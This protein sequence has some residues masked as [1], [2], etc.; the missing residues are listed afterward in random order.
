MGQTST[1]EDRYI[2]LVQPSPPH[3]NYQLWG[4]PGT[5]EH[6]IK[7]LLAYRPGTDFGWAIAKFEMSGEVRAK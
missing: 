6:C 5:I 2:A 7:A 4:T 3:G 1:T